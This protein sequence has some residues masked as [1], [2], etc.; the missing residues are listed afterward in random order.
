MMS[1]IKV[2]AKMFNNYLP[3]TLKYAKMFTNYLSLNLNNA[4]MFYY[5]LPFNWNSCYQ[6]AQLQYCISKRSTQL[7]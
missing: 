6:I 3:C 2:H 4:N 7:M 5:Y 1:F